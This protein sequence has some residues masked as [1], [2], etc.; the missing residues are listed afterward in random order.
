MK[1]IKAIIQP[2]MLDKVMEA[3]HSLPHFPGV[4]VSDC[5]GQGR[6]RGPGGHYQPALHDVFFAKQVKLEIFCDDAICEELVETIRSRAHTGTAGDGIIMVADLP[7]V[8]RIRTG[9]QQKDAT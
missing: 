6:G 7:R 5:Q 3:M 1:E 8:V 4:T 2:H 9:E